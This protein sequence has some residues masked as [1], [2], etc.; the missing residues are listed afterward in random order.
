MGEENRMR[1]TNQSEYAIR[2]VL[3][4]AK[5]PEKTYTPSDLFEKISVPKVFLAKILQRL[6]K[7]GILSSSR[8][9]SGGFRLKK[10][11]SEITVLDIV[12][13]VDGEIALNKCL[14]HGYD[15][16]REPQCPIHPIWA[17]A[18]NILKGVLSSKTFEELI[19]EKSSN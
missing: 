11:L 6:V 15:C 13:A 8:G 4:I 18:Q 5:N 1:I 12:E 14:I 16:T 7:K 9:A 2:A 19:K 3:E 10:R 17:E